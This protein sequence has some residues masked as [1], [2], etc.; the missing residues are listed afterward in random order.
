MLSHPRAVVEPGR[1]QADVGKCRDRDE[2]GKACTRC[3]EYKLWGCFYT[4]PTARDG[5]ASRCKA[6]ISTVAAERRV[7]RRTFMR[8]TKNSW[9]WNDAEAIRAALASSACTSEA[10]TKGGVRGGTSNYDR[11][12][13]ACEHHGIPLEFGRQWAPPNLIPD[14][15]VFIENSPYV[16]N[17]IPLKQRLLASGRAEERCAL[18]GLGPAWNGHPLTLQVDHI[19][20]VSNDH[21]Y[22][23]LRILCP[24]CHSQTPTYAGRRHSNYGR[25][26]RSPAKTRR[27]PGSLPLP[28]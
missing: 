22:E 13:R 23:N 18:C 1:E 3:D 14:E 24:N 17:S 5:H 8:N 21:R 2:H 10:L 7:P 9:F 16:F 25:G 19:N 20:G 27:R 15:A 28:A 6:C 4:S 11:L 12:R 26:T